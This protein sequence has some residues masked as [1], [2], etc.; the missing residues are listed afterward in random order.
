[1]QLSD[2]F[3]N[4]AHGARSEMAEALGITR[5]WLSLLISGRRVPSP[6]LASSIEKYTKGKVKRKELRPD[7]FGV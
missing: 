6:L 7:V 3:N 1:M 4:K 2:Y 5:T